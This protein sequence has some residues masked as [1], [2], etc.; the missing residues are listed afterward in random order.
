M[1]LF[2]SFSLYRRRFLVLLEAGVFVGHAAPH[3]I[4]VAAAAL[5]VVLAEGSV[6]PCWAD[7]PGVIRHQIQLLERWGTIKGITQ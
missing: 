2:L 4:V 7:A 1:R 3:V 5:C 6:L